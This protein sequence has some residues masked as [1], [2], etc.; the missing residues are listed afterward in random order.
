M[1]NGVETSID[2]EFSCRADQFGVRVLM[3]LIRSQIRCLVL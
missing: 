2:N 3:E 1:G